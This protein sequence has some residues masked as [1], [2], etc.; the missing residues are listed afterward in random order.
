MQGRLVL[1]INDVRVGPG[2]QQQPRRG[3]VVPG[4]AVVQRRAVLLALLERLAGEVGVLLRVLV[5]HVR[6]RPGLQEGLH[7][8]AHL[9]RRR[10]LGGGCQVQGGLALVVDCARGGAEV[11]QHPHDVMP[12]VAHALRQSRRAVAVRLVHVDSCGGGSD[13]ARHG[14]LPTGGLERLLPPHQHP[15][16]AE[17]RKVLGDKNQG[18]VVELHLVGGVEVRR[19]ALLGVPM[20]HHGP[21]LPPARRVAQHLRPDREA[22]R[23]PLPLALAAPSHSAQ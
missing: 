7:C 5:L 9:L 22:Q 2:L 8:R 13:L 10:A 3:D 20:V 23:L 12:A 14:C 15:L 1:A 4:G 19:E 16:A 17:L 6:V 18:A 11:Q 21:W